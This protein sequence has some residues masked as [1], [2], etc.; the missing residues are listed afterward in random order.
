MESYSPVAYVHREVVEEE[1]AKGREG[2]IF[3]F[4]DKGEVDSC[5]GKIIKMDEIPGQGIFAFI[6][7]AP[8]IR[9]DRLITVFGIPAAAYDEYESYTNQCLSCTGGY[10]L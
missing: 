5:A 8:A 9:I 10:D 2:K 1:I 4:N 6:D 3:F 7:T